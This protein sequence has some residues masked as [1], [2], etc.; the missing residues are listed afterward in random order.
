[1]R[2]DERVEFYPF[3]YDVLVQ[4]PPRVSGRYECFE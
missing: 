3:G 4:L 2:E 1:M